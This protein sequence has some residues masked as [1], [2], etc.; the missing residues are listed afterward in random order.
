MSTYGPDYRED[1]DGNRLREQ[2]ERVRN[3][4]LAAAIRNEWLTVE[5]ICQR[6]EARYQMRFPAESVGADIRHLR[7]P[8]FGGYY[9]PPRKRVID[10]KKQKYSEFRL[11]AEVK[12]GDSKQFALLAIPAQHYREERGR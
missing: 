5:E 7:K 10:G 1:R 6:L 12:R 9:I 8:Q 4:M 3:V 11:F 2:M